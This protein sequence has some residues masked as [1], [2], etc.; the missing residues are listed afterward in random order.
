[1]FFFLGLVLIDI[2]KEIKGNDKYL[3]FNTITVN[4]DEYSLSDVML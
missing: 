3:Q 2:L 4:E 1:M